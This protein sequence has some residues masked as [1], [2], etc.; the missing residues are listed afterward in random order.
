MHTME[1]KGKQE[2]SLF[3]L[4]KLY[5]KCKQGDDGIWD[6]L[7]M[8]YRYGYDAGKANKRSGNCSE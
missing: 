3:D 6:A 8:A 7:V 5:K 4:E 2:I 1:D